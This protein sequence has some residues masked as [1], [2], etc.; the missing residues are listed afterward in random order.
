MPIQLFAFL[1]QT[2]R[3]FLFDVCHDDVIVV[4]GSSLEGFHEMWLDPELLFQGKVL[5]VPGIN[6][7]VVIDKLYFAPQGVGGVNF[8]LTFVSRSVAA[9]VWS[10]LCLF[11]FSQ[12]SV[13]Q[14]DIAFFCLFVSRK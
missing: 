4:D 13:F 5:L 10:Q 7:V 3:L 14:V 11:T 12:Q 1:R 9:N 6:V 2:N 8:V